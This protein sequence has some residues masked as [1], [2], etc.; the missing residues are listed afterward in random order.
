[1]IRESV[2]FLRRNWL[3]LAIAPLLAITLVTFL[4][5]SA[6]AVAVLAQGGTLLEFSFL[7][8]ATDFGHVRYTF[9][10]GAFYVY[11][12][13]ALAPYL[14]WGSLATLGV[15]LAILPLRWPHA[16]AS[17]VFVWL[18][19]VPLLDIAYQ[20]VLWVGGSRNDL[21]NALGPPD[22]FAEIGI[23]FSAGVCFAIGWIVQ[24]RLYRENGL[25]LAG[26]LF[27]SFLCTL[28]IIG[29]MAV[30]QSARLFGWL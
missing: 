18:Y 5:E 11:E 30:V 1:V 24:R 29:F 10:E 20:S 22:V 6:H 14:M 19:V 7:P 23:V 8:S 16:I 15:M 28:A 12:L 21:R 13:I 17:T 9:P 25:S 4:H 27:L 26:Y 2:S 3:H